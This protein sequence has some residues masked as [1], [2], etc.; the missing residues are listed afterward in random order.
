MANKNDDE[1][2]KFYEGIEDLPEQK[3]SFFEY[4]TRIK[5][6]KAEALVKMSKLRQI[7]AMYKL[8]PFID[9]VDDFMFNKRKLIIFAI[10][11]DVIDLLEKK[12]SKYGTVVIHGGITS[13][14]RQ[15]NVDAF[16]NN[17]NIN[18]I[19]CNLQSGGVGLTL[20]AA[21][22]VAFIEFG[23]VPA[24][25]IQAEDRAWRIGQTNNVNNLI[26]VLQR[27]EKVVKGATDGIEDF[28]SSDSLVSEE[29]SRIL[30]SINTRR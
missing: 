19:I 27:K 6:H 30:K 16:Q 28:E 2:K 1:M 24:E 25:V 11:R 4:S 18:I 15:N 20:T 17:S 12:L 14:E 23:F 22:D 8:K 21:S 26:K 5:L 3:R 10:H 7:V 13:E 29:M 9:W